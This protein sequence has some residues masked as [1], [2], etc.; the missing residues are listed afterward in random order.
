MTQTNTWQRVVRT[1]KKTTQHLVRIVA[2][3]D[4]IFATP[5]HPFYVKEDV[6]DG[7]NFGN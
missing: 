1:F 7:S 4:T 6:A 2:G 5:E 3:K